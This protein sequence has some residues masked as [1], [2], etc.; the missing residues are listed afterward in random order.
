MTAPENGSPFAIMR[1]AAARV[2]M[3]FDHILG[4][5]GWSMTEIITEAAALKK[6]RMLAD[7]RA[8]LDASDMGASAPLD[9]NA[10][11]ICRAALKI[12]IEATLVSAGAV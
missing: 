12:E 11:R 8:A 10:A 3:V 1:D 4:S 6:A 2:E 9:P 7:S 5:G